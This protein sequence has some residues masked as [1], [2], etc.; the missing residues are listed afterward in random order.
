[1]QNFR[2]C[3]RV[4]FEVSEV[5]HMLMQIDF[6]NLVGGGWL[7]NYQVVVMEQCWRNVGET[8]DGELISKNSDVQGIKDSFI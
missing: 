3:G 5:L 1:M 6:C 7:M 8:K 2:N 4:I